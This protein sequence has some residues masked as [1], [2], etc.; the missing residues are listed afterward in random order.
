DV[1][2]INGF[3]PLPG[4][5]FTVLEN[6]GSSSVSGTFT[7]LPAGTVFPARPGIWQITHD[8]G[9]RPPAGLTHLNTVPSNP[10]LTLHTASGNEGDTLNLGGSFTDPDPDQ[11]HTIVINWGDGSPTKTISLAANL[12]SF[13]G[14]NDQYLDN[15]PGQPNGSYP[16]SVT[17]IDSYG[18][19]TGAS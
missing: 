7:R 19:F 3:T 18:S 6:G 4:S 12:V 1:S 10:V 17:V 15:P 13:S 14:V 9:S 2:L 11:T 8:G 5:A 16:I